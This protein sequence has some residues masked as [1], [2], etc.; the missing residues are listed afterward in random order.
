MAK[1]SGLLIPPVKVLKTPTRKKNTLSQNDPS[2][3]QPGN[4]DK[5]FFLFNGKELF[6]GQVLEVYKNKAPNLP[7]SKPHLA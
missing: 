5:H 3:V 6:W 1:V 7:F 2:K 4:Q